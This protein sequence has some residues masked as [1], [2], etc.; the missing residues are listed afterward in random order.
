M[1]SPKVW[2]WALLVI[3]AMLDLGLSLVLWLVLY[4]DGGMGNIL[5]VLAFMMPGLALMVGGT[6]L[7]RRANASPPE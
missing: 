7:I 3:G 6:V 1:S 4:N 2:G 5:F